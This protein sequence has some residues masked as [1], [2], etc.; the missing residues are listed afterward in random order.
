MLK[1]LIIAL[2]GIVL[3][4]LVFNDKAVKDKSEER[5]R[6]RKIATGEMVKDPI[7]GAYVDVDGSISVRDGDKIHRFCSYECRE[8]FLDRLEA[9]GR[10]LPESA[11]NFD[12][13]E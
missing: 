1:W 3:Y 5:Q 7:C 13:D 11:R 2:A 10:E 8:Q 6:A 4:K 12:E 9:A